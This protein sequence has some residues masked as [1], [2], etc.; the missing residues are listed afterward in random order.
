MILLSG[1][2][3]SRVYLKEARREVGGGKGAYG[4]MCDGQQLCIYGGYAFFFLFQMM[5]SL[6]I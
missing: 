2:D 6:M 4:G 1:N 3:S 5:G